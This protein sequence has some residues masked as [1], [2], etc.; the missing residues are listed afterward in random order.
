MYSFRNSCT[1]PLAFK[2][3]FCNF[4]SE[5]L[6]KP[7][8]FVCRSGLPRLAPSIMSL[9]PASDWTLRMEGEVPEAIKRQASADKSLLSDQ[10]LKTPLWTRPL[11]LD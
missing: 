7:R 11:A 2:T 10:Q 5:V 4:G 8:R 6:E 9:F 3:L 1:E